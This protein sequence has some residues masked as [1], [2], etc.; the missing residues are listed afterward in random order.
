VCAYQ[1]YALEGAARG[2]RRHAVPLRN[3]ASREIGFFE[4]RVR[5]DY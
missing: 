1:S 2:V 3:G 5:S 4:V